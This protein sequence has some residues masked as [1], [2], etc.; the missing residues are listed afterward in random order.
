MLKVGAGCAAFL[1]LVQ[2]ENPVRS[3]KLPNSLIAC[4]MLGAINHC[5]ATAAGEGVS[6]PEVFW[7][8]AVPSGLMASLE[9]RVFTVVMKP[10][11]PGDHLAHAVGDVAGRDVR[12]HPSHCILQPGMLT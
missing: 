9:R 7:Q 5:R 4:C 11:L 2:A 8:R 6:V 10:Q 3:T 12:F 1:A